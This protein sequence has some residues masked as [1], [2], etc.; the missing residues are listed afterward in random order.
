[1]S[2]QAT[3][4]SVAANAPAKGSIIDLR[5]VC[6]SYLKPSGEPM[7]VLDEINISIYEDEI[8]GLLGRSGS[9]KSTMLRTIGGLIAP[10]AGEVLYCGEP[11]SGPPDGISIVFQTFALF[12]WL[13]V[14]ENVEIALDALA[15]PRS[16]V[17]RRALAAIDLI[18]LDGFQSAYPRELSGGMRQRVGFARAIV[19]EPT[20]LLM[21]EPFS[22]LDVLTAELLRTD[23]V[24]L[25]Q[26]EKLPIKSVLLVTHNIEEAVLMCDRVFVLSSNPGR[27]AAEIANPLPHPRNRQDPAFHEIAD[28]IYSI[29]TKRKP[30]PP[31]SR[32]QAPTALPLPDASVNSMAGLIEALASPA[33]RGEA[34]LA[35]LAPAL[36]FEV[37]D[38]LPIADALN[39]MQF[40]ELNEGVLK[41]TPAG[42]EFAQGETDDRKHLFCKHLLASVPLAAHIHNV[43]DNRPR[44]SAPR[45][46]F[47]YELEDHLDRKQ[48]EAALRSII[49]WGRYAELFAYD[50]KT[51]TF[52]KRGLAS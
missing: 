10:S 3:G 36:N 27:I 44:H 33:Y 14:L 42:Q 2:V 35:H 45:G 47:Q 32:M 6:K 43:L 40:A 41:L 37:D 51:R 18:G 20:L 26:D 24:E 19:I 29:L 31:Q 48:C 39:L 23:L 22:A 1:M 15:I 9:G 12:P 21:D 34:E 8:L 52:T 16:E 46:R 49:A 7:P 50:D 13:T 17:R 11:L 30:E 28:E 5:G 25:W 38:L 4:A